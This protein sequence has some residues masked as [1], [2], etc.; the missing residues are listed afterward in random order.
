LYKCHWY[1]E[2]NHENDRTHKCDYVP[3][4]ELLVG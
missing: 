1:K 4:L 3:N 2:Y